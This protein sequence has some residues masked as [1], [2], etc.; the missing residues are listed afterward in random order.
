MG[1]DTLSVVDPMVRMFV[2]KLG[3]ASDFESFVGEAMDACMA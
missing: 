1:N 3:Y 2:R